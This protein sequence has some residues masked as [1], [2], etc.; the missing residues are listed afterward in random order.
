MPQKLRIPKSVNEWMLCKREDFTPAYLKCYDKG[1]LESKIDRALRCLENCEV[2]PR[3]CHVNRIENKR[4]ICLI[5]RYAKVSSFF[6]HF[7]EEDCLR[8]CNGSGTIFFS[9]CNLRCVFCQN[10]DVS[11]RGE[12]NEVSSKDIAEMMISLQEK[13]CHNIN[14]VT[15][16]HVVP[17]IIE[18]LPHAIE[19]GLSLPIVYNTSSYDSLE[20][21]KL[22]E[23]IVDIYMP[24]F[25]FFTPELAKFYLTAEDYPEVAMGAIKEMHSQLAS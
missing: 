16:E 6:P 7:G 8:G 17:Q 2:C 5:G 12:G 22:M 19:M 4:G 1:V 15:P 3:K 13:G 21:I 11:W 20:S 14:W 23:G 9:F 18:A 25:K 24:D 10:F